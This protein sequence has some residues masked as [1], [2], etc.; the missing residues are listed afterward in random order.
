M[1]LFETHDELIAWAKCVDAE[2][3]KPS[4]EGRTIEST[5]LRSVET[6]LKN[7][8]PLR[9]CM[10][11]HVHPF[12]VQTSSQPCV[13]LYIYRILTHSHLLDCTGYLA[14]IDNSLK[15]TLRL[16]DEISS[17]LWLKSRSHSSHVWL[18]VLMIMLNSELWIRMLDVERAVLIFGQLFLCFR[19]SV[20]GSRSH[21]IMYSNL[22]LLYSSIP[23]ISIDFFKWFLIFAFQSQIGAPPCHGLIRQ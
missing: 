17:C 6:V 10:R 23:R 9:K 7:K 3:R 18:N 11:R 21:C 2:I 8:Q 20:S 16:E 13:Y 22:S 12:W 15:V 5:F 4:Q 1:E 19:R 14:C